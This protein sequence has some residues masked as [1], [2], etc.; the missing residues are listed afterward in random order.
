MKIKIGML[1]LL[2]AGNLCA[3]QKETVHSIV[4]VRHES[5]WYE[6]QMDLWKADVDKNQKDANAWYNYYS[7]V[8]ALRI[9]SKDEA[10]SKKYDDLCHDIA[11]KAYEAVPETFEGNHLMHKDGG[12]GTVDEKYLEKAYAIAPNDPRIFDD[13]MIYGELNRDQKKF[14][15]MAV[16]LFE[17]Q[18]MP[19]SMLNW[20]YN[21]LTELD[22]NAIVF[23]AGDNDTYALWIVQEAMNFRT[24][25]Q[26]I[27]TFL[28]REPKYRSLLFKELGIPQF[29][30]KENDDDFNKLY[31]HI[32]KNNNGIPV[33]ASVSAL[34][35][36]E[37]VFDKD[38]MYLTGLASKYSGESFDN[39]SVIRRNY[40]KRYYLDHLEVV[41]T[42]HLADERATFFKGLY[43]PSLIKLYKHYE[44]CEEKEKMQ[45]T[46]DLII[47]IAKETNQVEEVNL[48]LKELA[49]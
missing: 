21:L 2:L 5:S 6:T 36:F 22:E 15:D 40:E 13:I 44:A 17:T 25:V 27:N 9:I 43:L 35:H 8:R 4:V 34:Q 18:D 7:A 3:Q 32:C 16:R 38:S 42:A 30:M 39:M 48:Q 49:D 29:E 28:I 31:G 11:K 46:Y 24:D 41:F 14:H 23:S 33:Y 19:G 10:L 47:R 26:V 20:A 37:D 1:V 12:T 45:S